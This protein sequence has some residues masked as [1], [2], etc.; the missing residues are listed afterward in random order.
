MISIFPPLL[1]FRLG[2]LP[3]RVGQHPN[4]IH[5]ALCWSACR[6]ALYPQRVAP[7]YLGSIHRLLRCHSIDLVSA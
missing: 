7:D 3:D 2:V 1:C 6:T 4:D 5:L